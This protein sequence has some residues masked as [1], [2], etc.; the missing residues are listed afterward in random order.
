MTG[1]IAG[2]G[3]NLHSVAGFRGEDA[4]HVYI[5]FRLDGVEEKALAAALEDLGEEVAYVHGSG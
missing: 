4:D 3:G 5:T 1:V 2:L